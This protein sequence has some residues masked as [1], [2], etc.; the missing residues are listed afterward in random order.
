MDSPRQRTRGMVVPSVVC[1]EPRLESQHRV[2][3]GAIDC[4]LERRANIG[5]GEEILADQEVEN[6]SGQS[7]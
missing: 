7:A 5:R 6:G 2:S 4:W 1:R 3:A